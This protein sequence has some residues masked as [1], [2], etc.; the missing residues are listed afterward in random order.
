M[1]LFART[2]CSREFKSFW[3]GGVHA[4]MNACFV[5]PACPFP[6]EHEEVRAAGHMRSCAELW[7]S[8]NSRCS[9]FGSWT[10]ATDPNTDPTPA[11]CASVCPCVCWH[12]EDRNI[13][14]TSTARFGR[15]SWL[16]HW[17]DVRLRSVLGWTNKWKI[18]GWKSSE[19]WLYTRVCIYM[20][21]VGCNNSGHIHVKGVCFVGQLSSLLCVH[22]Q[23]FCLSLCSTVR[24]EIP[25]TF[26]FHRF[27]NPVRHEEP[28]KYSF[29]TFFGKLEGFLY[30]GPIIWSI[31]GLIWGFSVRKLLRS[32]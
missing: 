27:S 32:D 9:M 28:F 4:W 18:N 6:S 17:I 21:G 7:G 22:T 1:L 24:Q 5:F 15:S 10:E 30:D 31:N 29:K 8:L 3:V 25:P 19:R 13:L 12:C 26:K 2:Y 23:C 14:L 20:A 11:L 16:Y